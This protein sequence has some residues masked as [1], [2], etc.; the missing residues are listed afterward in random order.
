MAE[1]LEAKNESLAE[2][3]EN[4]IFEY[5]KTNHLT[6]GRKLPTEEKLATMFAVSRR[7]VRESLSRLRMFG[8]L[9][10]KKRRGM[11]VS[12]PSIFQVL[13]KVIDPLF[14]SAEAQSDFYKLRLAIEFGIGELL[15]IYI[16]P[17]QLREL[18]TIVEKEEA[19]P[20]DFNLY[21]QCDVKF[22]SLLYRASG[23]RALES[24]QIILYRFFNDYDSR[25]AARRPDFAERFRIPGRSTHR[26]VLEALKTKNPERIQQAMRR[27]LEPHLR[28]LENGG[29]LIEEKGEMV[30]K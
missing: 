13:E 1:M 17:E 21:L 15:A 4:K 3:V 20:E 22:H 6:P 23:S 18:E 8:L 2:V 10:S 16:T 19:H 9:E 27:H 11:V 25:Y 12:S 26:T 5:L 14:L 28:R 30:E 7:S 29:K 24:F